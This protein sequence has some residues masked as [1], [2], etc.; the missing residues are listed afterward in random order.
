MDPTTHCKNCATELQG[1]FCFHCGQ[2]LIEGRLTVKSILSNFFIAIV[3]LGIDLQQH[4]RDGP[5]EA[6]PLQ[7]VRPDPPHR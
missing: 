7:Q 2:K 3:N 6:D 5:E 4:R 1:E